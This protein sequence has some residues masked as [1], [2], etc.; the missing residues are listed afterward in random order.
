MINVNYDEVYCRGDQQYDKSKQAWCQ[1]CQELGYAGIYWCVLDEI[2]LPSHSPLYLLTETWISSNH[3][4][5]LNIIFIWNI[6]MDSCGS[7][8]IRFQLINRLSVITVY[9]LDL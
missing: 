8:K 4:L 2:V 9:F 1:N 7:V 5:N 6:M 3:T